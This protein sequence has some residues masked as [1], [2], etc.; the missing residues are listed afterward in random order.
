MRRGF[1]VIWACTVSGLAVGCERLATE[2]SSAPTQTAVVVEVVAKVGGRDI[3][4]ADVRKRMTLDGVSARAAIDS[5]VE[6]ELLLQG[7]QRAGLSEDPEAARR[8]DRTMVRALLHDLEKENTPEGLPDEQVREDFERN[9]EGFQVLERRGSWHVLVK[10]DTEEAR[11]V[12]ASIL[13]EAR[14]ADDPR[15]VFDR[16]A[17][18]AADHLDLPVVVEDLPAMTMKA[19]IEKPYK[20]ALF[21]AKTL[22]PLKEP[23]LTSYGWHAI[24]VTG[25][26]P[27]EV[28]T[29]ADVEDEIRERL[30]RKQRFEKLA[31]IVQRLEGEGLLEYDEVLVERLMTVQELPKRV[32]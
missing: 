28:H 7:A 11:E 10:A 4:A 20:D 12:A 18:G 1:I 3:G 8:V 2:G 19:Q 22:G 24:V 27:G 32:E 14:N 29:F 16:Y 5:I 30:S 21:K 15:E 26:Q 6:E 17:D 23:I 13:A 25:I 31:E 9:R